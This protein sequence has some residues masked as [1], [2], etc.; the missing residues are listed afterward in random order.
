MTIYSFNA[1]IVDPNPQNRNRLKYAISVCGLFNKVIQSHGPE[2]AAA[3]LLEHKSELLTLK[4]PF[5][6]FFS[7]LLRPAEIKAYIEQ[8][9]EKFQSYTF[10]T[11]LVINASQENRQQMIET[12]IVLGID[13]LLF[14]PYSAQELSEVIQGTLKH[15]PLKNE[16]SPL[17][18]LIKEIMAE[19]DGVAELHASQGEKA[20]A[21]LEE[22]KQR[23]SIL[24]GFDEEDL[25]NY[26]AAAVELF[27][28][29]KTPKK[30]KPYRGA[31]QRVKQILERKKAKLE[32]EKEETPEI[33]AEKSAE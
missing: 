14:E 32:A 7:Y 4:S 10:K 1:L 12:A 9:K 5:Y 27:G 25:E 31:S 3:K 13:G 19:L 29:S 21:A 23:L 33:P 26:Y 22:F 11:V 28:K 8:T 18:M 6:I 17:S 24:E 16:F 15:P 30:I 2:D 20:K